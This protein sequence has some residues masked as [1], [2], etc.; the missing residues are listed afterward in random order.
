MISQ[1]R[2][3][4]ISS[5]VGAGAGVANRQ[6]ILR[7]IT[8][9]AALPPGIVMEFK[10]ADAVISYFGST[11][12]EAARASA[13][14]GF[15]S[16]NAIS[17][18]TLSF[19]RWVNAAIAPMVVGDS[20]TK[21]L[22][23]L[24]A[25]TTGTLT[26]NVG[27]TAV[28][29][30]GIDL[31]AAATLTGVASALQTKLRATANAQLATCNVTYNTNTNQ[32][33]LTGSVTGSGTITVTPTGLSTDLSQ[34][35]GWATAG[36]AYVAGQAADTAVD[37]I[38]KSAAIS[39]NFGSFAYCTPSV[40]MTNNDIAAVASW[41]AAQNNQYIY[42][43][44]TLLSNL[45]AL[46]TLTKGYAGTALN[47]LA[48]GLAND[49]VEQSP[50]EILASTNYAA[51]GSTQNFMYYQFANRNVTVSDDATADTADAS[52]G[53]Y[54]GLTQSAGQKISFYQRGV[55]CGGTTAATDMNTYANEMWL[56][57]AMSSV[58]MGLFLSSNKVPANQ[59]GAASILAVMQTVISQAKDNGTISAGKTLSATQQQYITSISGDTT[60]WRQ[61]A[62]I[63]YW[64][65]VTFSSY[66][67]VD[68]RTE[69]KANYTLI[70]AKD[71]AIRSVTGSD[72]MI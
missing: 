35:L 33:V 13:Y 43:V 34:L 22:D 29:V 49:F 7:L 8:Q 51:A 55:L 54:I 37:A 69:W 38:S 57:S 56:K 20:Q 60:A 9:N 65:S 25:Q 16:K 30:T 66:T 70:Y 42:S 28:P 19:A 11:S 15:I 32:F 58:I 64:V 14:F 5:G 12:E 59:T 48:T 4:N 53:N 26:M 61:V 39:N 62:S 3:I 27:G 36:T 71:D 44:P 24:L 21:S 47:V 68:N 50:C 72:V 40:A 31:S 17:P 2:Y 10:S 52:R 63:G 67:T 45:S 46:Y 23:S 18:S 6:L 41:N 1:S